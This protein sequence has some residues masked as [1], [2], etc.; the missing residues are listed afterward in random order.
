MYCSRPAVV[1]LHW[2]A[3]AGNFCAVHAGELWRAKEPK[4][5]VKI[6]EGDEDA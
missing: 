3:W 6:E 1:A 4:L 2:E 5:V